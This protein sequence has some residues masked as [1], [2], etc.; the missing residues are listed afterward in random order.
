MVCRGAGRVASALAVVLAGA[1]GCK[2]AV[3]A[4]EAD[5]LAADS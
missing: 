1:F 5:W 2:S 4:R 3:L